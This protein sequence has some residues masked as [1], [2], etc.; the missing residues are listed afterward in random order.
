MAINYSL[1]KWVIKVIFKYILVFNF[2]CLRVL[3]NVVKI[4]KLF[5]VIGSLGVR[6]FIFKGSGILIKNI[7]GSG[8]ENVNIC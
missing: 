1:F 5:L 7:L 6:I 4:K 8:R 2:W 3:W